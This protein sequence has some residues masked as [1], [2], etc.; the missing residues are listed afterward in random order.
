MSKTLSNRE[1]QLI[2]ENESLKEQLA[3]ANTIIFD[4]Y[5]LV[6]NGSEP[7]QY[8]DLITILKEKA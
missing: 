8:R 6:S 5:K 3:Y 2:S 7:K 1:K 4:A